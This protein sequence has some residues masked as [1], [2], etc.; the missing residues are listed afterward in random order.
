MIKCGNFICFSWYIVETNYDLWDKP[1]ASDDRRDAAIKAMNEVGQ[2]NITADT[3][4]QVGR[5]S[6]HFFQR[7]LPK[8]RADA[9]V[10]G[11]NPFMDE[12]GERG[13]IDYITKKL[14]YIAFAHPSEM[15]VVNLYK[16]NTAHLIQI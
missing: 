1:P 16:K 10:T 14:H 15:G 7:L 8:T 13:K 9:Y 11:I 6:T 2:A 3:L 4:V 5:I 12:R